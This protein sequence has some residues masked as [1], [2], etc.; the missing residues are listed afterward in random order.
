MFTLL[1]AVSLAGLPQQAVVQG[2]PPPKPV[3]MNAPARLPDTPQGKMVQAFIEAYN[4][5]NE[6]T[7][8]KAQESLLSADALAKRPVEQRAAMYTRMRGDFD[9]LVVKRAQATSDQI[10]VVMPDK[11]GSEAIFSFDFESAAPHKIKGLAVDIGQRGGGT[12]GP[13]PAGR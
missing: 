10:R 3:P 12:G 8:L 7:F 11:N 9:K 6:A 4:S 1:V 2:G 5:G 13:I